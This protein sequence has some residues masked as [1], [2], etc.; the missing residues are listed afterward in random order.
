MVST[1]NPYKRNKF[2]LT[3]L[4]MSATDSL[5]LLF[6]YYLLSHVLDAFSEKQI[7]L[8]LGHVFDIYK[9]NIFFFKFYAIF[10]ST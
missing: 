10:E 1:E 2:N 9:N 5:Y 8:L 7:L 3:H 4:K 6:T